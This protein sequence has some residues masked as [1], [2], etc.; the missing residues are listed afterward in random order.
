MHWKTA[1]PA[2]FGIIDNPLLDALSKPFCSYAPSIWVKF[3]YR[4]NV[5]RNTKFFCLSSHAAYFLHGLKAHSGPRPLHCRGFMITFRH[6]TLGRTP[7]DEFSALLRD[8]HLTTHNTHKRHMDIRVWIPRGNYPPPPG[9]AG[10]K[11]VY[12]ESERTYSHALVRVATWIVSH[13]VTLYIHRHCSIF[14][15]SSHSVRDV[16]A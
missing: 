15:M 6:T 11:L 12:P 4:Y 9:G 5:R 3:C 1:F 10:F 13:T 16:L 8:L 14:F 2:A 7:M